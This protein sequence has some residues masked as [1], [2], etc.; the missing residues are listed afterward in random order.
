MEIPFYLSFDDFQNNY[1]TDFI[2]LSEIEN[3]NYLEYLE[4]L[5][6]KYTHSLEKVNYAL[7]DLRILSKKIFENQNAKLERFYNENSTVQTC[8][9]VS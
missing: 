4:N 9:E 2:N 6:N 8:K 1:K 3:I 7:D 5:K